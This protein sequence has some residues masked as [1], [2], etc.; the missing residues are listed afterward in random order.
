M[1]LVDKD[2]GEIVADSC[3]RDCKDECRCHGN[4]V[5]QVGYQDYLANLLGALGS[6]K[7]VTALALGTQTAAANST[8][9]SIAGEFGGRKASSNSVVSSQTMRATAQ[10][11][12]NEATQSELG[13]VGGYNTTTG[14]TVMN[15]ITVNTS[16]KTTQQSLNC[17]ID[18][19]FS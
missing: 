16:Q 8:Q 12:T 9:T 6:S 5:T 1:Q 17:T 3:K 2:T 19:A 15:V 7:Q 10:W 14:G 18:Y 13:A 11:G 4:V